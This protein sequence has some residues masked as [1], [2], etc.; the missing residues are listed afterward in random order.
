MQNISDSIYPSVHLLYTLQIIL[1]CV[2]FSR[3]GKNKKVPEL[4]HKA[5]CSQGSPP[6]CLVGTSQSL[7]FIALLRWLARHIYCPQVSSAKKPSTGVF[8]ILAITMESVLV[9]MTATVVY[10]SLASTV[11]PVTMKWIFAYPNLVVIRAI[12]LIQ[13]LDSPAT[14]FLDTQEH[15]AL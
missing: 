9:L 10:V 1:L 14:A 15:F 6:H 5:T 13:E 7:H 2:I 8:A 11:L 4:S 3:A 12:A